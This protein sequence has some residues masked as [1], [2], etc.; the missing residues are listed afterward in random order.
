MGFVSL[1]NETLKASKDAT[2]RIEPF[3]FRGLL[4]VLSLCALIAGVCS[5]L[6]RDQA[7]IGT[8]TVQ[9]HAQADQHEDDAK[10]ALK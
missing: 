8:L 5:S 1:K 7:T 2:F 4:I 9:H 6:T 10:T 3:R